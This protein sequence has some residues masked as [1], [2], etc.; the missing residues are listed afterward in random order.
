MNNAS[1]FFLSG[2]V[3]LSMS[4]T[5]SAQDR[6][7]P[8]SRELKERFDYNFAEQHDRGLQFRSEVGLIYSSSEISPPPKGADNDQD[9]GLRAGYLFTLG[10]FPRQQLALH[11]SQWGVIGSSRAVLGMG[12]GLTYYFK[13]DKNFFASAQAG[14]VTLYDEAPD[15]KT[16]SQW[17]LGGEAS[18]GTGWWVADDWSM[19]FSFYAG[20]SHVDLDRDGILATDWRAGLRVT[21]AL[22]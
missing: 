20:G 14:A 3:L 16:F 1:F 2:I 21:L 15:I 19:G 5:V 22:N 10:A 11:M 4:T 17:G 13:P 9:R 7:K 12:P 6:I 8:P 18:V